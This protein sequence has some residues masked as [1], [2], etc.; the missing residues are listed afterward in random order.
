MA[1]PSVK[2]CNDSEGEEM[3]QETPESEKTSNDD[4]DSS[5]SSEDED[6]SGI[7][8]ALVTKETFFESVFFDMAS[9][10]VVGRSAVHFLERPIHR[11]P[12]YTIFSASFS[13][14]MTV[15]KF[16]HSKLLWNNLVFKHF[17]IIPAFESI[18]A[19]SIV[20]ILKCLQSFESHQSNNNAD[21][22]FRS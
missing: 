11:P 7:I 8:F 17:V 1:M 18:C 3:D 9:A 14:A 19:L 16:Y 13:L 15:F 2:D 21:I 12:L 5:S 6:S 22:V 20:Y 4:S 10:S